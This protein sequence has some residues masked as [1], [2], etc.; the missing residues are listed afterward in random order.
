[1]A[2]CGYPE[3]RT[4]APPFTINEPFWMCLDPKRDLHWFDSLVVSKIGEARKRGRGG[5]VIICK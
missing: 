2:W 1:M 4:G 3:L 5:M